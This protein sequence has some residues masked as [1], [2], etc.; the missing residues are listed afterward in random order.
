MA[1]NGRAETPGQ[2][3]LSTLNKEIFAKPVTFLSQ[4]SIQRVRGENRTVERN[5]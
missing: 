5:P 4:L 1:V 3:S 2:P